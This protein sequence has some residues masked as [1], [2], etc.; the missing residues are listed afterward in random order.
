MGKERYFQINGSWCP[1]TELRDRTGEL[2][3][4]RASN[5]RKVYEHLASGQYNEQFPGSRLILSLSKLAWTL[6]QEN[7]CLTGEIS[8]LLP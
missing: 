3:A 5:D 2:R 4:R 6:D 7:N 8:S 1:G